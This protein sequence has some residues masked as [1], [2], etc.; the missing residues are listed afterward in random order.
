ME[1]QG[2][3]AEINGGG[4][5]SAEKRFLDKHSSIEDLEQISASCS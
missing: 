2:S 5:G 3:S 4:T 1:L